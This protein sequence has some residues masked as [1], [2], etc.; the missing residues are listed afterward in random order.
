MNTLR[1]PFNFAPLSGK[2]YFPDWADKISQDV[3]FKDGLSGK[4]HL[5]ITSC[6]SI[7]IR[8]GHTE[9]DNKNKTERY[10]S[11]SK[12]PDGR[13]FI[14]AT[15]IK[16]CL[17]EVMEILSFGKMTQVQDSNFSIRGFNGKVGAEYRKILDS[18]NVHCGWLRRDGENSYSIKDCGQP[19]RISDDELDRHLNCKLAVFAKNGDFKSDNNKTAKAKYARLSGIDLS[20]HRFSPDKELQKKERGNRIFVKFDE[21]SGKAGDIVLTGQPGRRAL[22]WDKKLHK[23]KWTGKFYEFV[24]PDSHS[25]YKPIS[26]KVMQSFKSIHA[27]STDFA[28]FREPQLKEGKEIPVFMTFSQNG[29][30]ESIGLTYKFRY[31][32][33]NT[34]YD[35]I[36]QMLKDKDKK[37]LAECIFGYSTNGNSLKGRVQI[38]NAFAT[39]QCHESPDTVKMV[40]SSPHPSYYPLYLENGETWSSKDIRIAGRKRYPIRNSIITNDTGTADMVSECKPLDH[41]T[42]E[43]DICFFNLKPA[44]LG[45]LLASITFNKHPECF[46]SLGSGK[47]LGYGKIR[48]EPSLSIS[49]DNRDCNWF[50]DNFDQ[51]LENAGFSLKDD[52]GIKELLAMAK[53]I[54]AGRDLEFTYMKMSTNADDNEFNTGIQNHAKGEEFARFTDI[55]IGNVKTARE[56][57]DNDH[58]YRNNRHHDK[59]R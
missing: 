9:D 14:P 15:S 30:V 24:F 59:W 16:G 56:T 35:G 5:K 11:F 44:E 43:G 54:P 3:P 46:H 34:I 27:N 53:G 52:R 18:K 42:F 12:A 22:K 36:P 41:A 55:I 2:A 19:W 6:G 50:I 25:E 39:G 58:G 4:I 37:D 32:V 33:P 57:P 13:F 7:F 49:G 10:L 29:E 23:N 31:P 1:A 47:P 45:A 8:N 28:D 21:T 26:Q 20:G 51:T 17:R 40:L 38:G 48:I